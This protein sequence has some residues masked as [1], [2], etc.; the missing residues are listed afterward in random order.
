MGHPSGGATL[1]RHEGQPRIARYLA[2]LVAEPGRAVHALD[3]ATSSGDVDAGDA[4][5]ALDVE[6]RAA[7]KGAPRRSWTKRCAKPRRRSDRCSAHGRARAEIEFL[8]AELSRAFGLG[9]KRRRVGSA[10]ERARVAVTT[11]NSR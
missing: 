2:R 5:E 10:A 3:L 9:G 4:G 11:A 8:S 1:V 7:Y 6:A